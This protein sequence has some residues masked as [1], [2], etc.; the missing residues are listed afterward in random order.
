MS[1][2]TS[3]PPGYQN[4]M[5]LSHRWTTL[6]TVLLLLAVSDTESATRRTGPLELPNEEKEILWATACNTY[7]QEMRT[8]Q[9]LEGP[10]PVD[11]GE[12]YCGPHAEYAGMPIG[13]Y[14]TC[15]RP[16]GRDYWDCQKA[17]PMMEMKIGQ[18]TV[19]VLYQFASA[20]E[21]LEIIEYML[22]RPTLRNVVV[23]PNWLASDVHVHR[24][25]ERFSVLASNYIVSFIREERQGHSQ[26]RIERISDCRGDGCSPV[27][28]E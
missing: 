21:V 27:A 8:G 2:R 22:S 14:V 18:R 28:E 7:P 13:L 19:R 25:R 6:L 3:V 10:E 5:N 4:R 24:D 1:I 15:D 9:S 17:V 12:V 20:K 23:D 11:F 16:S 26:F